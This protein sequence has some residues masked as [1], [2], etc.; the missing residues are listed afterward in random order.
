MASNSWTIK[1]FKF[2]KND[3]LI[4]EYLIQNEANFIFE[5]EI[6]EPNYSQ[7]ETGELYIEEDHRESIWS[8]NILNYIMFYDY[9]TILW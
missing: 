8:V 1:N 6:E 2:T 5:Q 9:I 3:L 4:I 7:E